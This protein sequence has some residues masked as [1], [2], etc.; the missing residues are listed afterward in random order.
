MLWLCALGALAAP[1]AALALRWDDHR[2]ASQALDEGLAALDAPLETH[3]DEA[4]LDWQ[5]ALRALERA[6]RESPDGDAS[7]R[8]L[9]LAHVARALGDLSRGELVLAATEVQAAETGAASDP[10]VRYV[11]ALLALRR[12]ESEAAERALNAVLADVSA[13][14]VLRD[15]ARLHTLDR[16]LGGSDAHGALELAE[17]LDRAHPRSAA[18][19]NRLGLARAS[20][21]DD[22]GARAAWRRASELAPGDPTA[23]VS[24]AR[25]L[26]SRRDL[27]GALGALERAVAVAPLDP[28]VVLARAVVLVDLGDR[29]ARAS[30]RRAAEL[31]P[32]AAAPWITR[33]ELE[34]REGNLAAAVEALRHAL[35][36]APE[37]PAAWTNLGVALARQGE[38]V[39]ARDAFDRATR[40]APQ[41]GEA[42]NGLGAL[43]LALDD[44]EGA[45]GPLQHATS[46][47]R[48][49]PHPALNLGLAYE[50][51]RRWDEAAGAFREALRRSPGHP[52]AERHLA[53]LQP[54]WARQRARR[55]ADVVRNRP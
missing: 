40:R 51:L 11:R 55:R 17:A 14:L 54:G 21:G 34:L 43:R 22:T 8:A 13:P 20:V 29:D 42:W 47:L 26:R 53:A 18:T 10:H 49:D 4:S 3:P 24:L 48:E 46:L 52:V 38:R 12:G 2:R 16:L 23:W 1:P 9:A 7:Q 28:A 35:E 6:R 39:A 33:G 41:Q 31:D 27:T 32:R 50:R 45:L 36:L 5:K 37:D 15:R 19:A 30:V 44:P 25:Y